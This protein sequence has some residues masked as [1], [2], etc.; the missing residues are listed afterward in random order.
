MKYLNN[1]ALLSAFVIA[2]LLSGCATISDGPAQ[3]VTIRASDGGNLHAIVETKSQVGWFGSGFIQTSVVTL[4]ATVAIGRSDGARVRI[5]AKDNPGYKDTEFVIKGKESI[6]PWYYGN[7]AVFL[8]GGI[9]GLV[10]TTTIDPLS[11]SMWQYSNENFVVPVA[12]K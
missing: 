2:I 3:M 11:G 7:V 10:G 12:K 5:L 6:N 8:L 1:F 4:P 9:G